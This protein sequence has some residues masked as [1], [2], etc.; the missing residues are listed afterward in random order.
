MARSFNVNK[1]AQSVSCFRG[2]P[3]PAWYWNSTEYIQSSQ[4]D[5]HVEGT[6]QLVYTL[7]P[8]PFWREPD[9]FIWESWKRCQIFNLYRM[10]NMVWRQRRWLSAGVCASLFP[11]SVTNYKIWKSCWN[12]F[13]QLYQRPRIRTYVRGYIV[14]FSQIGWVA[15]CE[16]TNHS[17]HSLFQLSAAPIHSERQR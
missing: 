6:S 12:V 1:A 17:I 13:C 8:T 2:D 16:S 5:T 14:L 3:T 11:Y 10:G 4:P 9:T 7:R 15:Y